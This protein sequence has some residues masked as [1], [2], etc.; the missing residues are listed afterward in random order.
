M[1]VARL[2]YNLIAPSAFSSL[3]T[4]ATGYPVGNTTYTAIKRPWLSSVSGNGVNDDWIEHDY[5]STKAV[6]AICLQS[7]L[8]GS[9]SVLVGTTT[10]PATTYGTI[11]STTVVMSGNG[12]RK[13]SFVG[14][15]SA[16]YVRVD[17]A[18]ASNA[19]ATD[20]FAAYGASLMELGALY[21]FA[22]T[23]DLPVQALIDSSIS[24]EYPQ[25]RSQLA[26]GSESTIARGAP[27]TTISL[28]FRPGAAH[29]I[30]KIARLARAGLCWL[31]LG[32]TTRPWLQWPV[33]FSEPSHDRQ[34]SGGRDQVSLSFREV[35]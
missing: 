25:T 34:F 22:S 18:N 27:Y 1:T 6:A 2:H 35:T 13:G 8:Q 15:A 19:R 3:L 23:I 31:D 21:V 12:I 32:S 30:E 11:G 4:P 26:N 7:C 20:V 28:K 33:R 5:G 24:Y 17:F 29:D 14:A 16:R 10:P 9:G